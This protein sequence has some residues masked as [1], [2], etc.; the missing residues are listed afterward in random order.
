MSDLLTRLAQVVAAAAIQ[1]EID[2]RPC[3]TCGG[4]PLR[5]DFRENATACHVPWPS[6]GDPR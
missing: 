1:R 4:D 2:N 3:P 6:Q 5:P